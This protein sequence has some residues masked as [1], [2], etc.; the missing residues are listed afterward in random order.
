MTVELF[1]FD[2]FVGILPVKEWYLNV[3]KNI[4]LRINIAKPHYKYNYIE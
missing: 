3:Y 4:G 1:A 2:T